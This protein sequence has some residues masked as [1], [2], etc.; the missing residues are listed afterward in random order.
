MHVRERLLFKSRWLM[1]FAVL[2]VAVAADGPRHLI[3]KISVPG[4]YGL[5]C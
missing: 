5:T 3:K 4:D 1:M 2:A